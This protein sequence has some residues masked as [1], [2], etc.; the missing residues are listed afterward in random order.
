VPF[1]F[2]GYVFSMSQTTHPREWKQPHLKLNDGHEMPILGFGVYQIRSGESA[3]AAVRV[4]LDAGYRH[5]DTA[6]FYGNE[7]D[8]G[9]AVRESGIPRRE[10][11]VTT[12]LWNSDHGYDKALRAFDDSLARLGLEDVDLYLIH[13]PVQKKRND[14]WKALERIHAD[15]R[16]RSIGVSNY[17]ITHLEELLASSNTVPAVN[18]VEFSPFL[19]QKK[20][21]DYCRSKGIVLSAYSPLTRGEKLDDPLLLKLAVKYGKSSAQILIR[22]CIEHGVTP[23]PKS[24]TQARIRANSQVFD[25]GLDAADVAE[26]DDLN[27][28]LRIA[29]DPSDVP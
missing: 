11:F 20:L 25:F 1:V 3:A 17:V 27:R 22:W 13:W 10:I 9:R 26:L 15:G 6:A 4:A 18:Q 7:A 2:M 5:I 21:L 24:E 28:N 12:K 8:V 19:Y 23:L 29:W 16:A 14:T